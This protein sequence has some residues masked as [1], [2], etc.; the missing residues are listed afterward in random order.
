ML[1]KKDA[2]WLSDREWE[3]IEPHLPRD[4][5]GVTALNLVDPS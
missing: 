2:Y 5:R 3:A 1:R 4:W